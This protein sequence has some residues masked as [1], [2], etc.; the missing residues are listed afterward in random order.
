MFPEND[1]RDYLEHSARGQRWR[2][3]KYID[4]VNG[5]YIYPAEYRNSRRSSDL[6]N[7]NTKPFYQTHINGY[8]M[9][10]YLNMPIQRH[11]NRPLGRAR[12][13]DV[14]NEYY[15][16]RGKSLGRHK[17]LGNSRVFKIKGNKNLYSYMRSLDMDRIARQSPDN[18]VITGK[19]KPD[20]Q[21]R[22][23]RGR[24]RQEPS[25]YG[26]VRKGNAVRLRRRGRL[27]SLGNKY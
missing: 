8:Q 13:I 9:T 24:K 15:V 7:T 3:H 4:I 26:Y 14:D 5:R 11:K 18:L 12:K 16:E 21:S 23:P 25:G 1:Y 19:S 17:A 22:R 2:N 20:E 6:N 27:V 10:N